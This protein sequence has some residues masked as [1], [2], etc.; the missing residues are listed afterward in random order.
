MAA[1]R[2]A[3]EGAAKKSTAP[4]WAPARGRTSLASRT[5]LLATRR[6]AASTTAR[7]QR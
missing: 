1:P 4:S 5:L 7:E 6:D 2:S 3:Q